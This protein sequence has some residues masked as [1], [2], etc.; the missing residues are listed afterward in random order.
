MSTT[1]A[2]NGSSVEF[3]ILWPNISTFYLV[4]DTRLARPI[5]S[6]KDVT[7][8]AAES[9]QASGA[10]APPIARH[11]RLRATPLRRR[12]GLSRHRKQSETTD[13]PR[14]QTRPQQ[15]KSVLQA[16]RGPARNCASHDSMTGRLAGQ[17]LAISC[18]GTPRCPPASYRWAT[19]ACTPALTDARALTVFVTDANRMV[20]ARRSAC[21]SVVVLLVVNPRYPT[22]IGN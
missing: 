6:A 12:W 19:T 2:L 16:A 14:G 20:P 11:I 13:S 3:R 5:S 15:S 7:R 1:K 22:P 10:P 4:A 9:S 21:S 17:S 18:I 8:A